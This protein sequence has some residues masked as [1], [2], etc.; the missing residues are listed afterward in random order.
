LKLLYIGLNPIQNTKPYQL[1]QQVKGIEQTVVYLKSG[2]EGGY[3]AKENITQAAFD[4]DMLSGYQHV[5]L[6]NKALRPSGFLSCYAPAIRSYVRK[7][8]VVVIYGH[9]VFTFWIAMIAAK[10]KSKKLVLT[11]DA[12]YLEAT[13]ESGGW[14]MKM[15]PYFLR[16]LYNTL[17]SGV[18]VPSTASKQFLL[19]LGIKE[20]NIAITPYVVDED[21]ISKVSAN[22][23]KS[24]FRAARNIAEDDI[25][26]VFCAKFIER[27]RPMD[28]IHALAKINNN[29]TK[30]IMI[31]DGPLMSSLKEATD[32]FGLN[33]RVLFP[34]LV[35][36]SELPAYYTAS[37]ALVFCSDHEPYGLPV[38]EA[39]LC[40][41]PAIVS[42]RIGARLDLV[43]EGVTGWVYPTGNVTALTEVM[44]NAINN[45]AALATM[46]EAARKKMQG[47]SSVTNVQR[48]LDFFTAK[49]WM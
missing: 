31:G 44:Q 33:D 18:F 49:G 26:F 40:G 42:D 38:N 48:Q 21:H 37:D 13:A 39:M 25:V 8:D 47:W 30:L 10:F 28:A 41:I 2:K 12:T 16:W 46:G 14:K 4:N 20:D 1:M 7:N 34:G 24:T 5:I 45:K 22:T 43:E 35:K 29:K 36:Y 17:A 19:S 11:T 3:S 6:P 15:K 27:K 9:H 32:K 23:N